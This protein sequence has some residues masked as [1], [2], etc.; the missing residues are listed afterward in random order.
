M[1]VA[2][3]FHKGLSDLAVFKDGQTVYIEVKTPRGQL[4]EYQEEFKSDIEAHG[5]LY[6]L[7]RSVDDIAFLCKKNK[8]STVSGLA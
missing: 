3:L 2:R 8:T 6:V 4:S 7:I 5:G 1:I